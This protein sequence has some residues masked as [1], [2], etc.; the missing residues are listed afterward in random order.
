MVLFSAN[1]V[2][3][4]KMP[5]NKDTQLQGNQLRKQINIMR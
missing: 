2:C 4:F 3:I 1:D 5:W